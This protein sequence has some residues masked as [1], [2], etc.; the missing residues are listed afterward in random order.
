MAKAVKKAAKKKATKQTKAGIAQDKKLKAKK[1]G[2]R[3]SASGVAY[4]EKRPNRS[5][6]SRKERI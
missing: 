3:I 5:D 2:R 4:T 6:V 1:P